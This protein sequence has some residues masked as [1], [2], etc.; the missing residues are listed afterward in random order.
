MARHSSDDTSSEAALG[1]R[2]LVPVDTE[3]EKLLYQPIAL[4]CA[5]KE[6]FPDSRSRPDESAPVG[7]D[8]LVAGPQAFKCFVYKLAQV[9]DSERGG[10]T[11]T[12]IAVLEGCGQPEYVIA[13]NQRRQYQLDDV[14]SFLRGL[15][16]SVAQ[17]A[18]EKLKRQTLQ[19]QVLWDI[20]RFNMSRVKPYLSN[21]S[22]YLQECIA[23]CSRQQDTDKILQKELEALLSRASFVT[24]TATSPSTQPKFL[25]DCETLIKAIVALRGGKVEEA[26]V[27]KAR[28]GEFSSSEPWC[29]LRHYLGRL[30]SYRQAA[31]VIILSLERWPL[32]FSNFKITTVPSVKQ[33]GRPLKPSDKHTACEIIQGM[34]AGRFD[35]E[36]YL[37]QAA[38]LEQV[39][40]LDSLVQE[41]VQKM[42]RPMVHA[43]V[44]LH[45]YLLNRGVQHQRDYYNGWKYIGTSKPPCRLCSY[46]FQYHT[47]EVE[48]RNSHRNLYPRWRLPDVYEDQG[49][50]A[51]DGRLELLEEITAS[52]Q[53][54][55]KRTLKERKAPRKGHDSN[56]YSSM[57]RS[58]KHAEVESDFG[59][60]TASEPARNDHT[61]EIESPSTASGDEDDDDDDDDQLYI[62]LGEE[63][64]TD[65]G[66]SCV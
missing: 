7:H 11:I 52:A 42:C 39:A 2:K 18:E 54:D 23:H 44:L 43:E 41:Q 13:S 17:K 50:E 64:D 33:R 53:E 26:I 40:G 36:Q 30:H 28:E 66:G 24:D 59:S 8:P 6:A 1:P 10:N 60:D 9:C 58:L 57:P 61:P 63:T 56:T 37:S 29:E 46:Y 62:S 25:S 3:L 22:K 47:D 31:E 48:V 19:K 35:A 65:E 21:L 4:E 20:L 49:Q 12:A 14:S 45:D 34:T 38:E 5:I 32:L 27:S 51:V 15:L 55:A 16:E